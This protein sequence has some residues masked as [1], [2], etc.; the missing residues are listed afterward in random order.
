MVRTQK[1]I[2]VSANLAILVVCGLIGWALLTHKNLPSGSGERAH[3]EGI[4]LPPLP[5]Y[6]WGDHQKTLVLAIRKGCHYCNSSLPFYKQLSGLEKNNSL[7][8]HLLAVMPDDVAT[9]TA[10]LRSGGVSVDALFNQPLNSIQVSGTPTLFLVDAKGSIE[11]SWV[12]ELTPQGEKDVIA[13]LE[14]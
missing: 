1:I 7:H 3:L 2:E 12:G 6:R 9:G 10:D 11:R 14:K 5:G 4:T 8:A 13:T